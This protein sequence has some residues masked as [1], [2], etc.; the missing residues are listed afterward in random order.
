MESFEK[1]IK[2]QRQ[3]EKFDVEKSII[4]TEAY[5]IQQDIEKG[6]SEEEILLKA[7]SGVYANTWQNRKKG[8]V[9]QKYGSEKNINIKQHPQYTKEDYA[10]LRGKGWNDKQIKER[11][12]EEHANGVSPVDWGRH[13]TSVHDK[14]TQQKL[15]SVVDKSKTHKSSKDMQLGTIAAKQPKQSLYDAVNNRFGT[16][17]KVGDIDE[18]E[19]DAMRKQLKD[20][21]IKAIVEAEK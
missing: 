4:G 11:W 10:Y 2:M 21:D 16:N 20:D 7:K 5:Y 9:G 15:R 6:V 14:L 17:F 19:D 13:G 1:S 12:D 8:I 3:L 18:F